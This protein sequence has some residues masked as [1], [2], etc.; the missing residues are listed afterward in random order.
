MLVRPK[1][2]DQEIWTGI[3]AGVEGA[4]ARYGAQAAF[5]IDKFKE[6]VTK[7]LGKAERVYY[8]HGRNEHFDKLFNEVWTAR[9]KTLSNPEEI[10]H[11]MRL[12]KTPEELELMRRAAAISAEAH[13]R[14]MRV[15]RPGLYEYQLQAILEATFRWHGADAPA[16]GSIVGGGNN[17]VILHYVNNDQ[18]LRDGDLVLID[19]ACEY[20][21]YASDITRTFPVNGKFSEAQRE[22]Y[23]VVLRSQVAA[24]EAAKPGVPLAYVHETAARVLR[25]GLVKLGI[26]PPSA[27][28]KS[29]KKSATKA[30]KK[31]RLTLGDFFMHGTSHWLGIDVHDVGSYKTADGTRSDRGKGKQRLLE[32]G[33]VITV[34]PGLYFDKDDKRV[35]AKYRGI[36]VRIED[37]VVITDE[38]NE[39]ITAGVPKTVAE[40]EALMA[41]RHQP[42]DS[43][44]DDIWI[45]ER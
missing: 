45:G 16:Y 8:K 24:I 4:K 34:E 20:R 21:G 33:M 42:V 31:S 2:R 35:P 28:R 1:D 23:E 27:A 10:V 14:A 32:P 30:T 39:V 6:V 38:G 44:N 26:L 29:A 11:E 41:R 7:L 13:C 36:G 9:Q 22:I 3:R 25:R 43:G 12:F 40:V 19:A 5:T 37:D 17:A 18:V 15:S